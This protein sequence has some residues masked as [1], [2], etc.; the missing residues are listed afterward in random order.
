MIERDYLVIGAGT[1]GVSACEGIRQHDKRGKLMLVGNESLP[2]YM[3]LALSK[4]FLS[5]KDY[6]VDQ[7][8]HHPADWY[9]PTRSNGA[10]TPSSPRTTT[11]APTPC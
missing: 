7:L 5:E 11:P 9:E 1:A 8:A 10:R 3:R 6:P 4:Q 2:P